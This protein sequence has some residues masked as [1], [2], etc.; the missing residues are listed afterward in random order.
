MTILHH[1]W[2]STLF[3][4]AAWALTL[5][6][7]QQRARVR[8][9]VWLAA[10]YKFLVPFSL[11]TS[12]GAEVASRAPESEKSSN[13]SR[14]DS[15]TAKLRMPSASRNMSSKTISESSTTSLGSGTVSSSR[16]GTKLDGMK[17]RSSG[18]AMESWELRLL[19]LDGSAESG[20]PD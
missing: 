1:L 18:A 2:Q 14:K 8:Y 17:V 6:L 16:S 5:V 12:V 15:K 19:N 11:L 13:W 20:S 7:R 3:T 4:M 9:W 10:S